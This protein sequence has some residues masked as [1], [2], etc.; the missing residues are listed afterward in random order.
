MKKAVVIIP[1]YN[2][3]GNVSRV[4]PTLLDVFK[5]IP[6]WQM[7]ILV[8]DDSSPDKTYEVV[9]ELAKKHYAVHLLLNK[10]K[11][12]LG[13]AYLKGM[14]KAFNEMNADIVFEFDADLSHDP[15][16]I[17]LFLKEIDKGADLVLGSRYIEGGGIPSNWGLHRKFLS[18]TGNL[19]INIVLA[20]FSIRDW[21]TGYRALKK[22]VY[23][24]V[25]PYLRSERFSGYT[26]QI[27][28]LFQTIEHGFKV[29]EVPFVFVDRTEGHSK[30]GSEYIKNTLMFILKV[31]LAQILRSKVIKFAL[32]GGVGTLIQLTSLQIFRLLIPGFRFYFLTD[33]LLATLLSI[34]TAIISNFVLN[35]LWTFADRKL[36]SQDIPRKFIQ[37][38]LASTGSILIQLVINAFGENLFGI[39]NLFKLPLTRMVVDTGMLYAVIGILVG[40]FWNFFAYTKFIWKKS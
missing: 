39:F 25:A 21:T 23:E 36:K 28:F 31:R 34:E 37:F 14:D 24:K 16:K 2:E 8:V 20:N 26:F 35:N 17:P 10:N 3:R 18:I 15:Q 13:G 9:T 30:L 4:I 32:V 11:V 22:E 27:G 40:M 19:F 7:E 38:N 29:S 1:T 33:F 5:K 6:N 12:G